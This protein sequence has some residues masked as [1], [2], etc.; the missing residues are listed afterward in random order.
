MFTHLCGLYFLVSL[1]DKPRTG[2]SFV[3]STPVAPVVVTFDY[4]DP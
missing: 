2:T 4:Q 3:L 1:G